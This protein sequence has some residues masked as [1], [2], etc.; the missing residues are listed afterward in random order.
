MKTILVFVAILSA[1]FSSL[2]SAETEETEIVA[3]SISVNYVPDSDPVGVRF[4]KVKIVVSLP[5]DILILNSLGLKGVQWIVTKVDATD[6]EIIPLDIEK[7]NLETRGVTIRFTGIQGEFVPNLVLIGPFDPLSRYRVSIKVPN[8][9]NAVVNKNGTPLSNPVVI[10]AEYEGDVSKKEAE[11][12]GEKDNFFTWAGRNFSVSVSALSDSENLGFKY[13]ASFLAKDWT[14]RNDIG[15]FRS[16]SADLVSSGEVSQDPENSKWQDT[17]TGDLRFTLHNYY[18]SFGRD[19]SIDFAVLPIGIE[20][21][22]DNKQRSYTVEAQVYGDIL[23]VDQLLAFYHRSIGYSGIASP[24]PKFVFGYTYLSPDSNDIATAGE[25]WKDDQN[26]VELSLYWAIPLQEKL[27]IVPSWRA[28]KDIQSG[29]IHHFT[30]VKARYYTENSSQSYQRSGF[31]I[32]YQ[33]GSLPPNFE[34]A[35]T[36]G[37]GYHVSIF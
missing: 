18:T 11:E 1:V 37:V 14:L 24:K 25:D 27:C 19:Y 22:Q 33:R 6:F 31:E 13:D 7:V 2:F 29:T 9:P 23:I 35:E 16:I 8:V 28:F 30:E 12:T 10:T 17:I 36:V 3:K 15:F 4:S 34:E 32:V 5:D 20:M 26:R 21:D